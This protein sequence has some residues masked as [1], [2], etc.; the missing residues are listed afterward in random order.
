MHQKGAST[1]VAHVPLVISPF[2]AGWPVIKLCSSNVSPLQLKA[3]LQPF[4]RS[5]LFQFLCLVRIRD[6]IEEIT[7]Q[8]ADCIFAG[9]PFIQE[10]K[11]SARRLVP[12]NGDFERDTR[13]LLT[14]ERYLSGSQVGLGTRP[15]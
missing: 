4:Y 2:C 15:F 7:A 1:V 14:T 9:V 6:Q 5:M 11:R 13:P 8:G 12:C 3:S 10:L